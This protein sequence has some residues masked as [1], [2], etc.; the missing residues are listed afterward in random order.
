MGYCVSTRGLTKPL[1]TT[2]SKL[3][4]RL[5]RIPLG[6][7]PPTF[8]DA[9]ALTISSALSRTTPTT[10]VRENMGALYTRAT[11]VIA[12]S[13]AKNS[14]EGLYVAKRL[15]PHAFRVPY[16]PEGN[17]PAQGTV[18]VAVQPDLEHDMLDGPLG[19]RAWALQEWYLAIA[20]AALLRADSPSTAPTDRR[21]PEG[22]PPLH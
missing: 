8:R 5:A 4:D 2:R 3:V 12:A 17:S 18:N 13:G 11:F 10:G 14:L 20:R 1:R 7:L 9:V 15:E 21:R 16:Y 22:R 19:K 6:L